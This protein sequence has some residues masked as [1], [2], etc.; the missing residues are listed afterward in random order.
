MEFANKK[1]STAIALAGC[2][3]LFLL[4]ALGA[5][6]S[7]EKALRIV[8]LLGAVPPAVL[9][10]KS[11]IE[12][13]EMEPFLRIKKQAAIE[14][15]ADAEARAIAGASQEVA[16]FPSVNRSSL[17]PGESGEYALKII[18][19]LLTEAKPIEL[20]FAK[21]HE[22]A[23]LIRLEFQPKSSRQATEASKKSD[24][25][26]AAVGLP[27]AL[28][29]STYVDRGNLVVEIPRRNREFPIFNLPP[30]KRSDSPSL[31]LGI[32]S[33]SRE[34][35]SHKLSPK[36]ESASFLFAGTSGSGKSVGANAMLLSAIYRYTPEQI[37]FAIVDC[38]GGSYSWLKN[39]PWLWGNICEDA[40]LG[41]RFLG[42]IIDEGIRR[43]ELFK[44]LEVR[45]IEGF[46][47]K[48]A[49]K[50]PVILFLVDELA[51]WMAGL[52]GNPDCKPADAQVKLARVAQKMRNVGIFLA[53]G[54]QKPVVEDKQGKFPVVGT[55]LKG[56]LP[57][58][59]SF[60]VMN[61][62]ESEIA[63]GEPTNPSAS[64]LLGKGDFLWKSPDGTLTRGQSLFVPDDDN[65]ELEKLHAIALNFHCPDY[66]PTKTE[67]SA[68]EHL[69]PAISSYLETLEKSF[70][71]LDIPVASKPKKPNKCDRL[72]R[73]IKALKLHPDK[74]SK[75]RIIQLI[76]GVSDGGSHFDKTNPSS[77]I[78][79]YENCLSM[80]REDFVEWLLK[81]GT[82]ADDIVWAAWDARSG[83]EKAIA[84]DELRKI[85]EK[86]FFGWPYY[87]ANP[88]YP[89]DFD[90]RYSGSW[91]DTSREVRQKQCPI[92]GG[93]AEVAHHAYYRSWWGKV[94]DN[95]KDVIGLAI[96]PLAHAVHKP[97]NYRAI[98]CAHNYNNWIYPG[99]WDARNNLEYFKRLISCK[100]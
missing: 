81:I 16:V 97:E 75:T 6:L 32:N 76:W 3:W 9:G 70:Q 61:C 67:D 57:Y 65:T 13:D 20:N 69:N 78:S 95:E 72:W 64:I 62:K 92:T 46:N 22:G 29:V 24:L 41:D 47:K 25:I 56:N 28:A 79:Q 14:R 96:F 35:I 19:A 99:T 15:Y 87:V 63:L 91:A 45:D 11:E 89:D 55:L 43:Q 36:G 5:S 50:L 59:L 42:Q 8:L 31:I 26:H 60:K 74:P 33:L 2:T 1:R 93:K 77:E 100:D 82:N 21:C 48:S 12:S 17:P 30:E 53:V 94:A 7:G 85:A 38:K 66:Q 58:R 86:K 23:S 52:T 10:V 40:V 68:V 44:S 83:E 51:E 49:S 4:G 80:H 71:S 34:L 90:S 98:D 18:E 27:S 73:R 84:M 37:R 39:S 54:T 88:E